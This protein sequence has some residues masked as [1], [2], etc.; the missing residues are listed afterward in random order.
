MLSLPLRSLR[1]CVRYFKWN[2]AMSVHPF[3]L[4]QRRRGRGDPSLFTQRRRLS[5]SCQAGGQGLLETLYQKI[6]YQK[7][8]YQKILYQKIL[9]QKI[10]AHEP[11]CKP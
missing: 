10:M 6:L 9:H 8:L 5:A 11:V 7:I 3:I 2:G 1:L 4:T